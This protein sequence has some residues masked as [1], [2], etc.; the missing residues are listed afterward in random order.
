MRFAILGHL[1]SGTKITRDFVRNSHDYKLVK[2]G[3]V[4]C[5]KNEICVSL[6]GK[7]TRGHLLGIMRTP[8]EMM[9]ALKDEGKIYALRRVILEAIFYAHI[10][11]DVDVIQLGAL[12]TS[13]TSGGLALLKE[14]DK[15]IYLNHGDS[16]TAAIV[17]QT[18]KKI[19][20]KKGID[21]KHSRVAIVGAYGII[22]EVVS[23]IMASLTDHII[24]I[25]RR[26]EK[27]VDLSSKLIKQGVRTG[28]FVFT[29][30]LRETV[31]ADIVITATNHP[32]ALLTSENL[33]ENAV[34][35][36]VSQPVNVSPE[37]CQE[38]PDITR[39]DGG[40][41]NN[42]LGFS[43]VPMLPKEVIYACI[44]EV[45]MQALEE[46][47]RSHVG[48]INLD[49]LRETERWAEKYGFTLNELTNFGRP[50]VL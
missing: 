48:S 31:K 38:R 42:P 34:V 44:A 43:F 41:V 50:V 23:Q 6:A 18:V 46:D 20:E 8:E 11:L 22:G 25:G 47:K 28:N 9:A 37:L 14:K 30:D 36:D 49:F 39:V 7:K 35:V 2:N 3:N 17:C 21:L 45:I 27:L 10:T 32:S 13:V 26:E 40:F 24:F 12:T 29:T 5:A 19:A 16:F 1:F 4:F 15:E 33:K